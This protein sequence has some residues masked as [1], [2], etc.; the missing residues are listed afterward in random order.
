MTDQKFAVAAGGVI[1]DKTET[2]R[3]IP[4]VKSEWKTIP[5]SQDN[6]NQ[7]INKDSNAT[8]TSDN[9]F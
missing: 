5:G 1:K 9:A 7:D 8:E 6:V 4:D 3:T 2:N